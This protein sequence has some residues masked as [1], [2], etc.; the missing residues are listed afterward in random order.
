VHLRDAVCVCMRV[1]DGVRVC[2]ISGSV[3]MYRD[4]LQQHVQAPLLPER[5]AIRWPA[6]P[7]PCQSHTRTLAHTR[8]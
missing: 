1:D 3:C 5:Q 8:P 2:A 7:S 4:G 6:H